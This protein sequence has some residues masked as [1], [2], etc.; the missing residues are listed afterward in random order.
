MKSHTTIESF[1]LADTCSEMISK[2]RCTSLF[3]TNEISDQVHFG[4][5]REK[6]L[7]KNSVF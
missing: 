2:T 5:K 6:S 1:E 4:K 7:K 3:Q